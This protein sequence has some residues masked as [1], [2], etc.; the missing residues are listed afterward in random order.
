[1]I[2][3][4]M[5]ISA[6]ALESL[7]ARQDVLANNLANVNTV[8][9][10]A[11][12]AVL[13]SFPD[14]FQKELGQI[15]GGVR[16]DAVEMNARQGELMHTGNVFDVAIQGEGF[17]VVQTP[18]GERYTRSGNFVLNPQGQL[19]T[20]QGYT[21]MGEGGPVTINGSD[22]SITA[23]GA[24]VVDGAAVNR[25]RLVSF[26]Q[27][28][29]LQRE[30]G[31]VFAPADGAVTVLSAPADTQVRGGMLESSSV[32]A[33]HSLTQMLELQRAFELNQRVL[34]DLDES[35]RRSINDVG[36]TR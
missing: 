4:A 34:Q 20:Q 13:K 29:R 5:S 7:L 8:G 33:V 11:D 18:Q 2:N 31:N 24:V 15:S 35:L 27:P 3:R 10:K 30:G 21:V 25:L 14:I 6:S 19:T 26:E 17:F 1:M 9:F 36:R 16:I 28:Y 23:E 32:S 12:V 22:A